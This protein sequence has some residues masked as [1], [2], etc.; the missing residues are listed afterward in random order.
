MAIKLFTVTTPTSPAQVTATK[1]PCQQVIVSSSNATSYAIGDKTLTTTNG[2]VAAANAALVFGTVGSVSSFDLSD[3][4]VY[5][6]AGNVQ[7]IAILL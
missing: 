1:T 4:F 6:A 5:A 3:L 7:V 2:V